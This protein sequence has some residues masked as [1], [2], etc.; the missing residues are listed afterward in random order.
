MTLEFYKIAGVGE[1]D[2]PD[3]MKTM[4]KKRDH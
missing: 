1:N 3:N 4:N 2:L